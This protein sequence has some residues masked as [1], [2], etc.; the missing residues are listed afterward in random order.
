MK[1]YWPI[2]AVSLLIL[3]G[4]GMSGPQASQTTEESKTTQESAVNESM[5]LKD[6]ISQGKQ[7]KCTWTVNDEQT[8]TEGTVY[9]SGENF[10]QEMKVNDPKNGGQQTMYSLSDGQSLYTWNTMMPGVG[11]K[12]NMQE[13]M[14]K[15]TPTEMETED[16]KEQDT[17]RQKETDLNQD[18]N[19]KCE[20]W[21]ADS[22][23]FVL[24]SDIKFQDMGEVLNQMQEF[25]KG[26]DSKMM[27]PTVEE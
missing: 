22:N 25:Q 26:L 6:L 13:M 27:I 14:D 11:Y 4:C 2:L 10:K 16:S 12:V 18:Y 5:S 15:E 9:I 1:I 19:F 20:T 7:Q 17:V 23:Q 21:M 8:S 3:G 24:P